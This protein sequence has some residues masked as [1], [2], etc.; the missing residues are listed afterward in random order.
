MLRLGAAA[1]LLA[2][3]TLY[4]WMVRCLWRTHMLL[5]ETRA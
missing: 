3:L 4:A 5:K 2:A 1:V